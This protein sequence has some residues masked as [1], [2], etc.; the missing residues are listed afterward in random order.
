MHELLAKYLA[1]KES[2][3]KRRKD[4]FLVEEGLYEKREISEEEYRQII[5]TNLNHNASYTY[6][7]EKGK[8]VYFEKIP[9]DITDEE[10]DLIKKYKISVPEKNSVATALQVVA[11]I[12]MLGGFILGIALGNQEVTHGIYYQYT[13]NEFSFAVALTYWAVSIISGVFILGFAEIIKL[14]NDIKYKLK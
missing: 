11:W 1:E 10:M 13:T 14:L 4:A 5:S 3:E 8:T 2:L 9:I 7:R 6:D 12:L